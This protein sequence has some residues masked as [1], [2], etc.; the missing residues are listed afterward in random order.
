M[1]TK[2]KKKKRSNILALFTLPFIE[3]PP[4]HGLLCAT[5]LK[6]NHVNLMRHMKVYNPK[7][8]RKREAGQPGCKTLC[9]AIVHQTQ[10]CW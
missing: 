6:T 2:G 3:L 1:K 10:Q 7:E 4:F 9:Q 5:Q 8:E